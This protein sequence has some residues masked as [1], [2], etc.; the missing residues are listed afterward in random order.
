SDAGAGEVTSG[1]QVSDD[2]LGGAFGDPRGGADGADPGFRVAGDLHEHVPVPGQQRPGPA[3]P[4]GKTHTTDPNLARGSSRAK[5]RVIFLVL[6][7]TAFRPERILM[8]P[9]LG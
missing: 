9:S 8:V 7:L 3:V 1:L 2:G 4:L 6:L 5:T